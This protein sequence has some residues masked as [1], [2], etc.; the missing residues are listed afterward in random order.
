MVWKITPKG[1]DAIEQAEDMGGVAAASS[2]PAILPGSPAL[3]V[4]QP[5]AP[6]LPAIDAQGASFEGLDEGARARLEV[7]LSRSG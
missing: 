1:R 7:V 4:V 6:L 5:L 2:A 3:F